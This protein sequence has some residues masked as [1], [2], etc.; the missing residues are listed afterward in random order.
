MTMQELGDK[1]LYQALTYAKSLDEQAGRKILEQFQLEQPAFAQTIFGVFP[2]VIAA[3]S[4]SMAHL[5]MDLCFD[6]ICVFQH[7]FG[8]LPDQQTMGFEWL[9]KSA[10]LMD[11]ELQ[12]MMSGKAMDAQF[13]NKLQDR[14]TDRLINT[15]NQT[16]LI[17]FLDESI[18]EYIA[19]YPASAEAI[20]LTKTML[21]VVVQL[22]GSL[23]DHAEKTA[24]R[25]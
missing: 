17:N 2:S 1:A 9:E 21:F 7:G 5:F 22:F 20:R 19:E 25:H 14:F 10:A 24:N 3:Q 8:P 18:E 23:Y 15:N 16:G 4:Q 13:K 12:A 6:I 11:T